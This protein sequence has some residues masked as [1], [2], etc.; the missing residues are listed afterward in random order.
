MLFRAILA[1]LVLAAPAHAD[2][3]TDRMR[4]LLADIPAD[5]LG[6]TVE[7]IEW[8]DPRAFGPVALGNGASPETAALAAFGRGLPGDLAELG[9]I[10][11]G[12]MEAST[13]LAPDAVTQTLF[14]RGPAGE[15]TVF[16]IEAGAETGMA[17]AL[18]GQGYALDRDRLSQP[19]WARGPDS[20]M[21]MAFREPSNPFGGRTGRSGRI[22]ITPG[23]VV[24]APAWPQIEAALSP[25]GPRL[26]EA[27][28]PQSLLAALD[29]LAVDALVSVR[30]FP[31]LGDQ[32]GSPALLLADAVRGGADT[33]IMGLVVPEGTAADD[34]AR[35]IA[36]NWASRA[37]PGHQT[38]Y[39]TLAGAVPAVTPHT[40]GA[41]DVVTIT[42]DLADE[43]EFANEAADLLG[44]VHLYGDLPTLTA[45]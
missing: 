3:P 19:V 18:P 27:P 12:E 2:A 33:G 21:D 30:V 43:T 25:D 36:E 35:R 13:G 6:D 10:L 9:L 31:G 37:S 32:W 24:Y 7:V 22:A 4:A 5:A 45:E 38:T 16:G 1:A 41:L 40:G 8:G 29:T 39:A 15:I 17:A 14:L 44:L 34:F 26:S 23:Q 42:L 20:G 28:Q 11:L